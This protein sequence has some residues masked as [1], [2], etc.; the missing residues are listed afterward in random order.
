MSLY[1]DYIFP[2]VLDIAT[3]PL[4]PQ[5]QQTIA[6]A[7]GRVLEIGIGT[8]ANLPF[9][10]QKV[11]EIIGI[12]PELAMLKKAE[13]MVKQAPSNALVKLAVGDAHHLEFADNSFDTVIMCLVLCTIPDPLQALK[14]AHRVLKADG[15]L[16]FL[17]HV[18]APS[19]WVARCQDVV[20]PAWKH[21]ACGCQLNRDTET[22]ITQ[23]GFVF[24]DI[25]R[26]QHPK[27]ISVGGSIIQGVAVKS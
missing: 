2:V 3:K 5:R 18:R 10:S 4:K 6:L 14:E 12:E 22:T 11:S 17:E 27:L 13:L 7:T 25:Q 19:S 23:A 8:G 1:A 16:L 26:F 24:E 9:Y 21:L 15:Q 20:N